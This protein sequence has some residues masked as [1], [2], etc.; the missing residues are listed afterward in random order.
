[1]IIGS[2]GTLGII[3]ELTVKLHG[4]PS[5]SASAVVQFSDIPSAV[6]AVISTLQ[7]NL[8]MGRI[9]LVDELLLQAINQYSKTGFKPVPSL[10][11]EF[12]GS[13]TSIREDAELF[14]QICLE[15]G[16]QSF[17]WT[18]DEQAATRM[19]AARHSAAYAFLA[20][21]PGARNFSTDVCVPI[22][23]LAEC[24]QETRADADA[25]VDVVSVIAG[26]VGDGNFHTAFLVDPSV[27]A[28]RHQV[29]A[30][31][32]RLVA[33]ALAMEGTCSGEHGIGQQ[34]MKYLVDEFGED[35]V[36]V[37]RAIKNALDPKSIMNPGKKL[38]PSGLRSELA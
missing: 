21:R 6:N 8:P 14:E 13:H 20:M 7:H 25:N 16:C 23:R 38:P 18:A 27:A 3:T 33:R 9:E 15:F 28:E 37:M 24:I 1:L 34:K 11:V 5:A 12:Q 10:F 32:D 30:F 35:T 2:E 4:R 31:Y 17:D 36:D 19:W 22:S 29:E 26:H